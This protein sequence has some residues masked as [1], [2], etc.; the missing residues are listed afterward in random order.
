MIPVP[1]HLLIALLLAVVAQ[2][3]VVVTVAPGATA[4][5]VY[6]ASRLRAALADP[7]IRIHPNAR[8]KTGINRQRF[9]AADSEAFYLGRTGDEWVV[10]GSDASGV[11]YGCLELARLVKETHG[12]PEHPNLT[13]KPAFKIRG[14]NLFWMKWGEKGYNWPVTPQNFPWFFD[15]DLMIGYL[16]ELAANR[17]NTIYF[18]NGHPFPYFLKLPR[19]PEARMLPDAELERNIEYMKWFTA[20]ADKRGLWTVF[21]FYNIHV[22]PSFAKAHE[23]EGVRV[24][25]QAATPL[26]VAYTR[27][28]ISEFVNNYPSVGLMLTAGEALRVKPEEFVR[29][30]II[31]GIKDTGKHPPLIVRQWTIDP[32][33]YRDV[34]KPNYDNLYTMMKHNTEMIV[35]PHPDPRHKTWIAFGQSHLVNVHENSDLKPFRWGSPVFI[36]QMTAI[37]KEMGAS[38]FHLYPA[39]SWLWPA[40]LDRVPLS[41]ID[42]D[43]IWIE[44]FG[45]YGWQP[46][47]P[48]AEEETFWKQRLAARFG[49]VQAGDAIYGYYVRT[50]PILPGL[51]NVVNVYNMNFHPTAV[52]QEATLNGILHSDRWQGVGDWLARPLDDFTLEQYEKLYGAL[53]KAARGRPPL[54]VKESLKPHGDA[55]DPLKLA[56]VFVGMAEQSLATLERSQASATKEAGEFARFIVDNRC[57]LALARFYRAKLEAAVEKGRYDATGDIAHYQSMLRLLDASLAEYRKLDTMAT[58]A[59]RLATDLGEWYRWSTVRDS[60]EREAAFY[61][62]QLALRDRGADVAYLGLDGPM[63]DA[64][65]TFHWALEMIR[66]RAGRS[67]QSYALGPKPFARARLVVVYD[68][69]SALFAKHQPALKDWV[70]NGGKL[71]IFDPLARAARSELLEG[72]E[73]TADSSYRSAQQFAFAE[74]ANPLIEGLAGTTVSLDAP[75]L[76]SSVRA[77]S[78]AW[79][80]LAYTVLSNRGNRQFYTG[81]PTFGPRWTSLMDTAR[82]P[83]LLVRGYGKG[84]VVF[85][86]IGAPSNGPKPGMAADRLEEAPAY[87]RALGRNLIEWAGGRALP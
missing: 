61:H 53:S 69:H 71:L 76:A 20:E 3:A 79:T 25:N 72:I 70:Q 85:A 65:N 13:D 62:E 84:A 45:R 36:Q 33:R 78:P 41:T 47:R 18:W 86:Q 56:D 52:S 44:A 81:S 8:V 7:A 14:T 51:Q 6:G 46:N 75:T 87:V 74:A 35:S 21:H 68:T 4:R 57:V 83:V 10:E 22:P 37:W 49:S 39:T 29:D 23:A 63:N 32:Y 67:A 64:T 12:L 38:G 40:A 30:A 28:A 17:Y 48:P 26:L 43:R 80:E 1:Y 54:S 55:V 5:E 66:T 24:E 34:I 9:A 77:A 59:Y 50:G 19:Y 2:A 60:F 15:R 58:S 16:D 11:L 82:V 27:Y 73:F 42:R 31:A